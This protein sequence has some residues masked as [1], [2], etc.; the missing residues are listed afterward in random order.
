MALPRPARG[1]WLWS[2]HAPLT[3]FTHFIT[4]LCGSK[5]LTHMRVLCTSIHLFTCFNLLACMSV[6]LPDEIPE[7]DASRKRISKKRPASTAPGIIQLPDDLTDDAS[8]EHDEVLL[9]D[10]LLV[11]CC[12]KGCIFKDAILTAQQH[13]DCRGPTS[14]DIKGE[15][16]RQLAAAVNGASEAMSSR[17]THLARPYTYFNIPVCRSAFQHLWKLSNCKLDTLANHAIAGRSEPPHDLRSA[18]P[19]RE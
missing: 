3:A 7:E 15:M 6:P 16:F 18:R 17:A 9:P 5:V 2:P 14:E 10:A 11:N 13:W 8:S 1:Y 19:V 12:A 4:L